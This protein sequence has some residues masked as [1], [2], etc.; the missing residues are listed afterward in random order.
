M[1]TRRLQ[2]ERRTGSVH[3]PKTGVLPTVLCFA[4]QYHRILLQFHLW[5]SASQNTF[6]CNLLTSRWVYES[7]R[8]RTDLYKGV[9]WPIWRGKLFGE[10]GLRIIEKTAL[11]GWDVI[12]GLSYSHDWITHL[13]SPRVH[14]F[15]DLNTLHRITFLPILCTHV[16]T[17][18]ANL[19]TQSAL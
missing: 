16:R 17:E 3:R 11:C 19:H 18:S 8:S 6:F 14:H 7:R 13:K 1:V 9:N 10:V 2:A 5:I 12:A 15:L 4:Q